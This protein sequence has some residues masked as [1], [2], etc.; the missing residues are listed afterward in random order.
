MRW[1]QAI[2]FT[3]RFEKSFGSIFQEEVFQQFDVYLREFSGSLSSR[4]RG[5]K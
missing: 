4:R 3:G 2:P 1:E 5:E